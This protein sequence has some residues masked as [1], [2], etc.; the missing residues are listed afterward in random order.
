MKERNHLS[1]LDLGLWV[2]LDE[3]QHFRAPGLRDQDCSHR[4]DGAN[5][6]GS[7]KLLI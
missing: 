2:I 4:H 3:L 7:N 1:I 6:A 5:A